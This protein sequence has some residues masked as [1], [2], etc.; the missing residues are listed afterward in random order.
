MSD[1][2]GDIINRH[3]TLAAGEETHRLSMKRYLFSWECGAGFGHLA[4]YLKLIELLLERGHEVM[5]ACRNL[6]RAEGLFGHLP[7][8]L[9]Q[10]PRHQLQPEDQ[11]APKSYLD[12]VINQGFAD[13]LDLKARVKAWL[14]L[15]DI[16][17]SQRPSS[18]ITVRRC[19]WHNASMRAL[20]VLSP[21]TVIA[22]R[23]CGIRF[24]RSSR[25]RPILMKPP[26]DGS[27]NF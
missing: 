8:K 1:T 14:Q 19:C 22:F 2:R 20:T 26:R 13:P 5:F 23:H 3:V 17:G 18:L 16:C 21:G 10:S 11:I 6:V 27:G 4:P 15:L 9:I 24:H 25:N 12:V 7:V